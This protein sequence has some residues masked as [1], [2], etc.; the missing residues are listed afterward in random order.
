[1]NIPAD[2]EVSDQYRIFVDTTSK[3]LN[4]NIA[5]T[6]CLLD[7]GRHLDG[8][9]HGL[10]DLD[11]FPVELQSIILVQLDLKTL[12]NFRHVNRQAMEV[13]DTLPE[14]QSILQQIPASLRAMFSVDL[15]ESITCQKFYETLCTANCEGCRQSAEF[16]YL[17]KCCRICMECLCCRAKSNPITNYDAVRLYAVPDKLLVE[18]QSIAGRHIFYR[19][20][21]G[22]NI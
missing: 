11:M 18:L 2:I 7:N 15:G 21:I 14:Y 20:N 9:S 1:M 10:G 12:T 22:P 6:T 13:V 3:T 17:L 16:I 5:N 4:D 19:R 8:A